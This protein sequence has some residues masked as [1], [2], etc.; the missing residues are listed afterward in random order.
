[1]K[2]IRSTLLVILVAFVTISAQADG[3]GNNPKDLDGQGATFTFTVTCVLEPSFIVIVDFSRDF[4][5]TV[6]GRVEDN[7][8]ER[9]IDAENNTPLPPHLSIVC[10]VTITNPGG[11]VDII[12]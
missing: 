2:I 8:I 3:N 9:V 1:M 6:K 4:G 5:A 11:Q 12:Y 10:T 7:L